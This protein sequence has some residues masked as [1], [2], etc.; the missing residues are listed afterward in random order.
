MD[1]PEAKTPP[2]LPPRQPSSAAAA[3][4][5]S[6][7]PPRPSIWDRARSSTIGALDAARTGLFTSKAAEKARNDSLGPLS[8]PDE[9]ARAARIVRT[10]TLDA[11]DLPTEIS[12]DERRKSQVILRKVPTEV[13][14]A[15]QGVVVLT[16]LK[17]SGSEGEA[18]GNGVMLARLQDGRWSPPCAVVMEKLLLGEELDKDVYDVMLILRSHATVQSLFQLP[19]F[20]GGDLSVSSGPVGNGMMLEEEMQAAAIWV[21]AKNKAL[22]QPLRLEDA[23]LEQ[24]ADDNSSAYGRLVSPREILE[25]L[26]E[27]PAWSE[28][29]HHTVAAAEGL[30]FQNGLI[31]LGP[32]SSETFLS[33]DPAA[34]SPATS[35]TLA[36]SAPSPP[37]VSPPP[38]LPRSTASSGT[39]F[40]SYFSRPRAGSSS[41]A[42]TS[43]SATSPTSRRR[44]PKEELDDED[45]AARREMEEAMRSFGIEDP[46]INLKSRAEDP[47]LVVDERYGEG[48]PEE[49][50]S[51]A[52]TGRT[53]SVTPELTASPGSRASLSLL[54]TQATSAVLSD[55]VEH[56]PDSPSAKVASPALKQ[57]EEASVSRR[58]STK[59]SPR[60]GQ[61]DK[62]PV[63][64]R[65][66]PRIGTTGSPRPGSPAVQQA[67]DKAVEEGEE[68]KA[69]EEAKED[70]EVQQGEKD[71]SPA[72]EEQAKEGEGE[73]EAESKGEEEK[74]D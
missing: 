71:A 70:G 54:S 53:G 17:K 21:Y 73:G 25:G 7:A 5:A 34:A 37:H 55:E 59:G 19:V 69:A 1:E 41:Q 30:D 49:A 64:P 14:A 38:L 61:G 15:A 11:A 23:V 8:P 44:L 18:A 29:L 72:G 35:P 33:P 40:L 43:P 39:S 10:F 6:L 67:D 27:V 51:T 60:V 48:D 52:Q 2:P 47:L 62:P 16:V 36:S 65:R 50:E 66:T 58:G 9:C 31:P 63:P 42:Q 28:G 56:P 57:V 13:V 22:Y 68:E 12:L 74:K 46:S 20:L 4:P 26:V 45:L 32:S 3:S 24:R